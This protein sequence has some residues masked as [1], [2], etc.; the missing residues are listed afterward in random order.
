MQILNLNQHPQHLQT[1]AGWHHQQWA[2]LNPGRSLAQRI[3][4]MQ[5]YLSEQ[6]VPSTFFAVDQQL[7]GS[8]AII[9]HDMDNH[10]ELTPWLASV[11]V[12]PEFRNQGIG[13]RLV[14]HVM[15]VAKTAGISRLYLFTPDRVAFY[16]RLGWQLVNEE[17][18][19]QHRVSIM[20]VNLT[21]WQLA[22]A[23]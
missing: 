12:A 14:E 11:L 15:Q 4:E 19:R 9:A 6:L 8:A 18:Y 10:P 16:E 1:L 22:S 17:I 5:E 13:T 20:Q 23:I 2:D 3:A 21:D 7:L